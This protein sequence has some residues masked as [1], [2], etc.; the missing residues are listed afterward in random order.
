MSKKKNNKRVI[1]NKEKKNLLTLLKSNDYIL[2]LNT[3]S[4]IS[5]DKITSFKK[6]ASTFLGKTSVRVGVSSYNPKSKH[7]GLVPC[8]KSYAVT[9]STAEY[10]LS[11][12]GEKLNTWMILEYLVE[13]DYD[14]YNIRYTNKECSWIESTRKDLLKRSTLFEKKFYSSLPYEL[15]SKVERQS[16]VF[17]NGNLYYPDFY[18]RD[19]KLIVEIDGGYHYT[20]IQIARDKVR[21]ENFKS[22][23]ITTFRIYNED[24]LDGEYMKSFITSI[25]NFNS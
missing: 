22:I 7:I 13:Y 3:K 5:P 18:F 12:M 4:R 24:V 16:V 2:I 21:D 14:D 10:I 15:K 19:K 11:C 1:V 17:A 25:I 9:R 23:G 20:P 6:L 8:G